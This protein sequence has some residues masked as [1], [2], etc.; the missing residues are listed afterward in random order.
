MISL[1]ERLGHAF[2]D[3]ALLVKALTHRSF[4]ADHNE[5]L[6]FIGDAVLNC[7]VALALFRQTSQAET[8]H[9]AARW[10]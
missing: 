9:P 2:R 7:V 8:R 6:E 10:R 5:R 3:P 4:N 1:E